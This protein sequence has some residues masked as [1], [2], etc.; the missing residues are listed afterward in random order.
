M[1]AGRPADDGRA[2]DL[3]AAF[4]GVFAATELLQD[5]LDGRIHLLGWHRDKALGDLRDQLL[6]LDLVVQHAFDSHPLRD[7]FGQERDPQQGLVAADNRPSGQTQCDV[8]VGARLHGQLG[9][10]RLAVLEAGEKLVESGQVLV[11][12]VAVGQAPGHRP[13]LFGEPFGDRLA[14]IERA[15]G[16]R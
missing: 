4:H 8:A 3:D 1:V 2:E 12:D 10:V 5:F 9:A 16:S 6:H 14:H 13:S 15:A 11:A 7:V